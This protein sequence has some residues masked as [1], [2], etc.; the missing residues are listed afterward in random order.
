MGLKDVLRDA[1]T[2]RGGENA[3]AV[4]RNWK[5]VAANQLFEDTPF[6]A[7]KLNGF[8]GSKMTVW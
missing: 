6:E 7:A 8:E 1:K 2:D 5:D 4:G 3:T